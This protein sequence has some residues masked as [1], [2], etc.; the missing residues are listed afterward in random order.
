MLLSLEKTYDLL[1]WE[2]IPGDKED[3]L[4]LRMWLQEI[5]EEKGEFWVKEHRQFLRDEW[6][7]VLTLLP[8]ADI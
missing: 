1:G 7:H 6:D 8:S 5:V 2:K 3:L 4:F